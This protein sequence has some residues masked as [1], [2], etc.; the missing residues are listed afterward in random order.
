LHL[1]LDFFLFILGV[2]FHVEVSTEEES[3]GEDDLDDGADQKSSALS[4]GGILLISRL[5]GDNLDD[6]DQVLVVSVLHDSNDEEKVNSYEC[7]EGAV[8]AAADL[9]ETHCLLINYYFNICLAEPKKWG[10]TSR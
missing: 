7:S 8:E 1:L 9:G 4:G 3:D 5:V 6:L 10:Y 2:L